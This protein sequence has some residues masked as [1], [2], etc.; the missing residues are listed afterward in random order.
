MSGDREAPRGMGPKLVVVIEGPVLGGRTG[1]GEGRGDGYRRV[2][3]G[4]GG[5]RA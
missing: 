2:T 3:E 1:G 5:Q 4:R